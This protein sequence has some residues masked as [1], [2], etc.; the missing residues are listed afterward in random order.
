M[1]HAGEP[2]LGQ[3]RKLAIAISLLG[4]FACPQGVRGEGDASVMSWRVGGPPARTTPA[5]RTPQTYRARRRYDAPRGK[6]DDA[7]LGL[8]LPDFV[9]AAPAQPESTKLRIAVIGDSLAE[10][11]GIG[12]EADPAS[13]N[14]FSLVKKTVS[15]SGLVRSDF[16][17]WAAHVAI[18]A[19]EQVNLAA[20]V[21][22]L[23]LNDRQVLR[24]GTETLEPLSDAWK[25]A[26]RKRIDGV[27]AASQTAKVPLI[28]VGLPVVRAP[29]LSVDL[30]AINT[31]IRERVTAAGETF[32]ETYENF[33][34]ESGSFSATGPDI[35]GDNVRLRGPDGIHFTPAGQRKLAFFIDKPLRKRV[36]DR[37]SRPEAPVLA[38]LPADPRE[39]PQRAPAEV[40]IPLPGPAPIALPKARPEIGEIRPLGET[41]PAATLLIRSNQ[42]PQDPATRNLFDRGLSP[43]ARSGRAD[44]FRWKER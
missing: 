17:D 29:K 38:A 5:S 3:I 31:L 39:T 26:Y 22:M 14:D 24:S 12:M 11:L 36:G 9:I 28:W 4:A 2:A 21:L 15:A 44:D 33:A 20:F 42:P 8:H 27:I 34:D 25:E 18:M 16:H 13:Q 19:R 43:D 41:S 30:A 32:V 6:S 1:L 37:I 35:I 10:A 7:S 40:T 23:G